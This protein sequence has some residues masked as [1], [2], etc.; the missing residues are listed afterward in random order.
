MKHKGLLALSIITGLSV[1]TAI[2]AFATGWQGNAET[3]W[4]YGTNAD[5][6][7][8]HSNGWQWL[9]GNGDGIAECYYFDS[10]GY[11]AVNTVIEGSTVDSNGAWIVNGVVQT[12]QVGTQAPQTEGGSGFDSLGEKYLAGELPPTPNWEESNAERAKP[13]S[14]VYQYS[15]YWNYIMDL[16]DEELARITEAAKTAGNSQFLTDLEKEEMCRVIERQLGDTVSVSRYVGLIAPED[17]A[18][19]FLQ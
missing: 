17:R 4:W 5:N 6:S 12:K 16:S 7:T 11:L 9:D 8:W 19:G 3:G 14:T 13:T 15:E 1:L 2:P 10:N 18:S